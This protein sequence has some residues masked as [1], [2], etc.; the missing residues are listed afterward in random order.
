MASTRKRGFTLIELLV[1]IAIIAILAAILFPVFAQAREKARATSCM[2]NMKQIG[3]AVLQYNQDYDAKYMALPGDGPLQPSPF[4]ATPAL[5]NPYDGFNPYMK[6]AQIW[7]CPS[8]EGTQNIGASSY[9]VN[10]LI[11]TRSGRRETRVERPASTIMMRETGNADN[12]DAFYCRPFQSGYEDGLIGVNGFKALAF[13][14]GMTNYLYADGHVK[15]ASPQAYNEAIQPGAA[16]AMTI[17][18]Q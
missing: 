13:H 9:H 6:S 15:A 16:G 10:G 3:L 14:V 8:S 4:T 7:I 1:V 17:W 2:S 18:P 5:P 12:Y 11:F